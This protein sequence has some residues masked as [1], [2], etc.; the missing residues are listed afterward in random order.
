MRISKPILCLSYISLNS[1]FLRENFLNDF[2]TLIALIFL[3]TPMEKP[4][5]SIVFVSFLFWPKEAFEGLAWELTHVCTMFLG[6]SIFQIV[7][8]I[9]EHGSF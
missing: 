9:L 8:N 3:I 6:E 7:Q 4:L 5:L 1:L 2:I